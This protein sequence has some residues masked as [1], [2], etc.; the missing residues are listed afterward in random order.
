MVEIKCA[1]WTSM[2]AL[3]NLRC[4]MKIERHALYDDLTS[5]KDVA[6]SGRSIFL[7]NRRDFVMT[8]SILV[9]HMSC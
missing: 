8:I 3:R 6:S 9:F 1:R 7:S 4:L 2:D 5:R